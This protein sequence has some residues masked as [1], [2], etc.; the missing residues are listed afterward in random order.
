MLYYLLPMFSMYTLYMYNLYSIC[1]SIH[2]TQNLK[3][4]LRTFPRFS[5]VPQSKFEANRSKVSSVMIRQRNNQKLQLYITRYILWKSVYYV[6]Y[7]CLYPPN[8][9]PMHST[10]GFHSQNFCAIFAKQNAKF[11]FRCASVLREKTVI[12]AIIRKSHF[13][14]N[15][16]IPQLEF[17][18][19][20]Q[21]RYNH[22]CV[23]LGIERFW[24][25]LLLVTLTCTQHI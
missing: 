4:E 12:C 21:F 11:F 24:N 5:R 20:P 7:F 10:Q 6:F 23:F 2:T 15:C 25:V 17:C 19:I 1:N 9:I 8:P 22:M 13:A 18:A 16:P 14:Q 3:T